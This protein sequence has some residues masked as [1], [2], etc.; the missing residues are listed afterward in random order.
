MRPVLL[1]GLDLV[2]PKLPDDAAVLAVPPPLTALAEPERAFRDALER[3]ISGAALADRVGPRSRVLIVLEPP[4]HLVPIGELRSLRSAAHAL[5][6]V[7][8]K[9]GV[10]HRNVKY[11]VANG[12]DHRPAMTE[13]APMLGLE[14]TGGYAVEAFDAE[15]HKGEQSFPDGA[16]GTQALAG[17]LGEAEVIIDVSVRVHGARPPLQNLVEGLA[18]YQSA[19]G[20]NEPGVGFDELAARAASRAKA[21]AGAL[22]IFS[23]AV[24]QNEAV[25]TPTVRGLLLGSGLSS[26]ARAWNRMPYL[27]RRRM[28][29][30]YPSAAA[31]A[32][33]FAGEPLDAEARADEL[34]SKAS[35]VDRG[36]LVDILIVPVPDIGPDAPGA[37]S[38]PILAA[39]VGVVTLLAQVRHRLREGGAVVLVNPLRD[40]IDRARHLPYVE[41]YE[42]LLRLET[43]GKALAERFE[44]DFSGRPEF[45]AAYRKK[46]AVHGA[47]PFFRW[48]ALERARRGLRI[49][50]AGAGAAAAQ[51][52]GLEPADSV[53]SA[54]ERAREAIGFTHPKVGVLDTLRLAG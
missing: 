9:K 29:A 22:P 43:S 17:A 24:V 25:L 53:E 54:I 15:A 3:P 36:P 14:T 20:L 7:L 37:R 45:V 11:L 47:H 10:A 42:N 51:R 31:P 2:S 52:V 19:R 1:S 4:A 21:L 23:L 48:Y 13:L 30:M 34:V 8:D 39:H 27:V 32:A 33:V 46:G 41:F 26:S 38:N 5:M 49:Y 50:A 12:L 44:F 6:A 35:H 40:Q 16:G 18:T 28:V